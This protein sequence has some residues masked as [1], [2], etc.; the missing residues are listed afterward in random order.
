VLGLQFSLS[1]TLISY[2]AWSFNLGF[3]FDAHYYGGAIRQQHEK[4]G[5]HYSKY[6]ESQYQGDFFTNIE[7]Y[8]LNMY[9]LGG[10]VPISITYNLKSKRKHLDRL[11]FSLCSTYGYRIFTIPNKVDFSAK[12]R[13][14]RFTLRYNLF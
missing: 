11:C 6:L 8:D 3:A 2:K 14:S 1:K 13:G 7:D 4:I 9:S 10:M 5:I 12:T